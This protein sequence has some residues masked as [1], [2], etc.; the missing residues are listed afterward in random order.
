MGLFDLIFSSSPK[1]YSAGIEKIPVSLLAREYK[2]KIDGDNN[3]YSGEKLRTVLKSITAGGV[4]ITKFE[5]RLK[6][7]GLKDEQ[8]KKRKELINIVKENCIKSKNNK[9]GKFGKF[10]RPW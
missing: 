7:M 9:Y 2:F 10:S 8:Y 6:E 1:I 5:E 4:S 3:Y